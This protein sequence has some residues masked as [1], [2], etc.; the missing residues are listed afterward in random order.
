MPPFV[1]QLD[2]F[3]LQVSVDPSVPMFCFPDVDQFIDEVCSSTAT[4]IR[5]GVMFCVFY[6]SVILHLCVVKEYFELVYLS[7]FHHGICASVA[8]FSLDS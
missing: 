2:V 4:A 1:S 5:Y 6:V 3:H 7:R 8:I